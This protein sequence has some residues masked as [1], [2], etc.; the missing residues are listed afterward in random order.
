MRRSVK[1]GGRAGQHGQKQAT[2]SQV[3]YAQW[4]ESRTTCVPSDM[5]EH[6]ANTFIIHIRSNLFKKQTKKTQI[7]MK[8]EVCKI[9][10]QMPRCKLAQQ[11]YLVDTQHAHAPISQAGT[12]HWKSFK[13]RT[14]GLRTMPSSVRPRDSSVPKGYDILSK[15]LCPKG[16]IS[17]K[18]ICAQRVR[19]PVKRNKPTHQK[20]FWLTMLCACSLW[21]TFFYLYKAA[22]LHHNLFIF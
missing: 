14:I 4:L 19:Y 16:T 22:K 3:H 13:L 2:V 15:H 11:L 21:T 20:M 12:H 7:M 6:S 17:C 9:R 1:D 18:N 8:D 10:K 5:M